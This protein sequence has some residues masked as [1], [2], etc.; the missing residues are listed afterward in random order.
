MGMTRP[1]RLYIP[2]FLLTLP[3]IVKASRHART[4]PIC[5]YRGHFRPAGRLSRVDAKCPQ[6]KSHERHRLFW[7]WFAGRK[8]RLVEPILHFA[9]EPSLA[10]RF[11][12]IYTG[13][14][15]AD[16]FKDADLRLDIEKI[17]LPSNS[18]NT[19]ICNHVLEHV[20]DRTALR[21]LA[22]VLS[23]TGALICSV[24]IVEGW[25]KTYENDAVTTAVEREK[26]FG[27]KGH[28]RYYGRDFR[29][30]LREAGFVRSEEITAEGP[31]VVEYALSPGE[32]IFICRKS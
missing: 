23:P 17:D 7:L 28:L 18:V 11:R 2:R 31:D 1:L 29:D 20:S 4:C 32:K 3:K 13:Y 26:H 10:D 30:R 12:A 16:L 15:T 22:R 19:I 8:D 9:P 24:P 21:E 25:D 6:C 5:G 14:T 27:Q